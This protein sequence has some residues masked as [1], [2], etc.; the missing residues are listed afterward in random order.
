ML[1]HAEFV[2]CIPAKAHADKDP[3]PPDESDCLDAIKFTKKPWRN[4]KKYRYGVPTAAQLAV[5]DDKE[6]I[7]LTARTFPPA[8][9]R[10]Y[11]FD[12]D[13]SSVCGVARKAQ[14]VAF[15]INNSEDG[16]CAYRK[17][18]H[19]CYVLR[20]DTEEHATEFC[21]MLRRLVNR[22]VH[23]RLSVANM[24][25]ISAT[26]AR[27]LTGGGTLRRMDAPKRAA[28]VLAAAGPI[29]EE[30]EEERGGEVGE[31]GEHGAVVIQEMS[32]DAE[33]EHEE[34]AVAAA[35]AAEI[36]IDK[37]Q[38]WYKGS[39]T[40]AE[41]RALFAQDFVSQG[42]FLIRDSKA[43]PNH[44]TLSVMLGNGQ[45][46]HYRVVRADDNK[47]HVTG[48]EET[49]FHTLNRLIVHYYAA[50][51]GPGVV[52]RRAAGELDP[53]RL[54]DLR[55]GMATN[56]SGS[57]LHRPKQLGKSNTK[58]GLL[59]VPGAFGATLRKVT[60]SS[61]TAKSYN[62]LV[63]NLR[64]QGRHEAADE[65]ESKLLKNIARMPSPHTKRKEISSATASANIIPLTTVKA[66]SKASK[67]EP[68][69]DAAT[70]APKRRASTT[71]TDE[72]SAATT[73]S[74]TQPVLDLGRYAD[75]NER[76]RRGSSTETD[77]PFLSR[78]SFDGA[79]KS[80][81]EGTGE[82]GGGVGVA[83]DTS[84]SVSGGGDDGG[85]RR[86]RRRSSF[87][88]WAEQEDAIDAAGEDACFTL[89]EE[90][91]FDILEEEEEEEEEAPAVADADAGD[92]AAPYAM[93][94]E[95]E[96]PLADNPPPVQRRESEVY[97]EEELEC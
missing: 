24:H 9:I 39:M 68:E 2:A 40:K 64:S 17:Y 27:K 34:N 52:I 26:D 48:Q 32:E 37:S 42:D 46:D 38:A 3:H 31:E 54:S 1:A 90:G 19:I 20:V 28:T 86:G 15:V 71:E 66:S 61:E 6:I 14:D 67:S 83:K 69:L 84:S 92:A 74:D 53:L 72:P 12:H 4:N 45:L 82:G 75:D 63:Q 65:L 88:K 59:N 87:R 16:P 23:H 49:T 70:E 13:V 77:A 29:S 7:R 47:F 10:K 95:P 5:D 8:E 79:F 11:A 60:A 41:S 55:K 35:I 97:V 73:T 62:A 33:H 89:G 58:V 80:L 94:T 25:G 57:T 43:N 50:G 56:S 36:P 85:G 18:S 91:G 21:K 22:I 81:Q 76:R 30:E 44:F 51:L 78:A 93:A 96:S